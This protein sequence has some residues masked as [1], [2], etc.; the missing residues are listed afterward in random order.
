MFFSAYAVVFYVAA[1]FGF[2]VVA[3]MIVKSQGKSY[4]AD[5][6]EQERYSMRR[7]TFLLFQLFLAIF[8]AYAVM[9]N[10]PNENLLVPL[11]C[12]VTMF[13]LGKHPQARSEIIIEWRE[14]VLFSSLNY[15]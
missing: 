11:T 1:A 10:V 7:M 9:H 8:A 14:Q 12:L 6:Q 5:E 3:N 15:G 13:L 4:W 2:L